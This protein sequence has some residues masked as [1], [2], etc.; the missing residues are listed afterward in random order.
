MRSIVIAI[1]ILAGLN[2]CSGDKKTEVAESPDATSSVETVQL[3]DEQLKQA[4]LSIGAVEKQRLSAELKLNGVVDVPPQNMISVSFPMGGYLKSTKLIPGMHVSKGELIAVMEDQ[5]LIQLQ[6]DF[7]MAKTKSEYLKQE[8]DRQTLLNENK[9]NAEK[10]Y[11][12]VVSDYNINQVQLKGLGEKLRLIGINPD[13][14][15]IETVSRSVPILSPINGFVSKV[16][17]NIGKFVNPSDVLFE[18]I[19]PDDIHVALTVFEKDIEK[20]RIG[21]KVTLN[22]ADEPTNFYDG[23]VI[24]V[25]RNLDENRSGVIHCHYEKK[26]NHLMP[27]MF[28]NAT[29]EV[30]ASEMWAVPESAIARFGNK[31]YIFASTGKGSFD[32]LEVKTG[33]RQKGFVELADDAAKWQGKQIVLQNAYTLL[34]KLKNTAE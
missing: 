13:K 22:V 27:G 21:Q 31:E 4:Q 2:A 17:V 24:L 18:L 25:T 32:M 7:L 30:E 5:T 20:I 12:Q 34:G 23:E 9:V 6:Q 15:T 28:I 33:I 3:T 8:L 26:P 1:I 11:Q 19:N 29:L 10:V 14:L 16:N